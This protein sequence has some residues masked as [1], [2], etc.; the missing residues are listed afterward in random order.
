MADNSCPLRTSVAARWRISAIKR[1]NSTTVKPHISL[2]VSVFLATLINVARKLYK[3]VTAR[4]QTDKLAVLY[5]LVGVI[6]AI[7]YTA[8][9]ALCRQSIPHWI[10][11]RTQMPEMLADV[12]RCYDRLS[13]PFPFRCTS[14]G[15]SS[16][17]PTPELKYHGAFHVIE[18]QICSSSVGCQT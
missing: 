9:L 6:S 14:H 8:D 5:F 18:T 16:S 2:P 11:W 10:M 15:P 17:V 7:S 1:L 4:T 3:G 12:M 13:W